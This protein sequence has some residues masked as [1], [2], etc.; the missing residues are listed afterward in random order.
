MREG[1]HRDGSHLYPAFPY[2]HYTL[3]S[4]EDLQALYA[5]IMTRDAVAAPVPANALRFPFNIRPLIAAWKAL[6]FRPSAFAPDATQ[7]AQWNRGAYLVQGPAHCGSCH[8]P[9]NLLGAEK[10]DKQLAGGEAEGWHAP[11]LNAASPSPVPW[12]ADALYR[13]LRSGYVDQHAVPAGPMTEVVRNLSTAPEEDVRAMSV[14]LASLAAEDTAE[15]RERTKEVLARTA[16]DAAAQSVPAAG[17]EPPAKGGRAIYAA[18]CA[19]CHD[20]GRLTTS[21]G[22]ALQLSLGSALYFPTA[23][24]LVH[25]ILDGIIPPEGESGPWMPGYA[26]ALTDDQVV[27]LVRFLRSDVAKAPPWRDVEGDV[28]KVKR[29]REQKLMAAASG[30]DPQAGSR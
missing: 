1:I 22:T 8:T 29:E 10:K 2:D 17:D 27:A 26:G 19:S 28:Q 20:S 13:Y 12:T 3:M 30:S 4:D 23:R 11:A 6:Y 25:I 9:R 7:S 24:N 18:A 16:N 5:F 15:R 21:S 14:Y